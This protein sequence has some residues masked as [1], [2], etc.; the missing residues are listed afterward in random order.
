MRF[1]DTENSQA[2][3]LFST[4]SEDESFNAAPIN[5]SIWEM[6]KMN[7]SYMKSVARS[8]EPTEKWPIP[9]NSVWTF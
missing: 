9:L 2:A 5:T 8:Y 6:E 3:G 7:T 1:A 4:L